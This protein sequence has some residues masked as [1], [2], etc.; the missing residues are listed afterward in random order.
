VGLLRDDLTKPGTELIETHTSWVFL[1]ESTVWKVKKPVDFGFLD[2]TTAEKRRA[3][4]EAEVRLNARLAPHVYLGVV[5]IA[6]DSSGHHVIGGKGDVVDWAVKMAR[7]PDAH[8]ADIMLESGRLT[9]SDVDRVGEHLARFHAEMPT[10]DEIAHFGGP[11]AILTNVNENFA[12]TR[13]AIRAHLSER[14]AA[15]IEATQ[16]EFI[17]TH[18][19]FFLTRMS[20]GRVRDGHGD[21]RLEHVYLAPERP[22]TIIDCIEFNERFRYADVCADI[23]F[24][25]MDLE[26]LG[27]ADLAERLLAAY[28]RTSGDYDLYLLV[29]FYEGY[30]AHVRGKVASILSADTGASFETRE[31]ARKNARRS[32]LLALLEGREALLKPALI[33][34]GGIIASGKSTVADAI[35]AMANA[36]VVDT[37]RTR[38][39]MLG[40]AVTTPVHDA[41]W[42]GAYAPDFTERVYTEVLRRADC[43]LSSG[44]PV[45]IDAS[46]RSRALRR[47]AHT[48]ACER[49]VPFYFVE[50][51]ASPDECRRRLRDRAKQESVSDGR[52]EVFDEFLAR[53]EPADELPAQ[54]CLVVD[55]CLPLET[56]V[57]RLRDVLPVWPQGFTK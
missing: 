45:V 51:T 32:Y 23:A 27:R 10:S 41:A 26:R 8:R 22:P 6:R 18:R 15:E 17:E 21:L 5:P 3:A 44:R 19:D 1:N 13:E 14:E 38:K 20:Q 9:P 50:C 30:R 24:L 25:S 52:L 40:I 46:F 56:N 31:R 39:H 35:G 28:A 49:G 53:W 2:F 43:V 4:C 33:A 34:V 47:R 55:T 57:A 42:T 29:N 11:E 54:E 48:I 16:I 7:L 37:D 36:P 12:Q